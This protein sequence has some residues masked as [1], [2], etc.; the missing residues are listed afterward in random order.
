[1]NKFITKQNLPK[2]Y[3]LCLDTK[4]L[5][6]EDQNTKA[7]H[8]CLEFLQG[9]GKTKCMNRRHTS[10]WY[11]HRVEGEPHR[12]FVHEGTFIL[13]ALEAGFMMTQL[14]PRSLRA[15]FNISERSLK[16]RLKQGVQPLTYEGHD[17]STSTADRR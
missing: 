17:H 8:L 11:K 13:A 16:K 10:S 9:M 6:R 12:G 3:V 14:H 4:M 15:V 2:S 1:M 5:S 7:Y